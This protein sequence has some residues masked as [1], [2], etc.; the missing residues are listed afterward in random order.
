MI[1]LSI[2]A[3]IVVVFL[4]VGLIL[5]VLDKT[6][7]K[8][9]RDSLNNNPEEPKKLNISEPVLSFIETY[10]EN[11]KR[12]KIVSNVEEHDHD[13]YSQQFQLTD[14]NNGNVFVALKECHA[15]LGYSEVIR[16]CSK[17]TEFLT[18]DE[19]E[20]IFQTIQDI[21]SNRR[22]KIH[23]Y[24]INKQRNRYIKDYCKENI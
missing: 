6:C 4:I 17:S 18:T 11:P 19:I 2:L 5:C 1:V 24:K 20:F 8:R 23:E 10:K 7:G 12:F 13:Y 16:S 9:V 15:R 3:T 21:N 14:Q 22:I